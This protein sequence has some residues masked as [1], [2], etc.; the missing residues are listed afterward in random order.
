MSSATSA[1]QPIAYFHPTRWGDQFLE[2]TPLDKATQLEK[3]QE[4]EHLKEEVRKELLARVANV[5]KQLELLNFVDAIERLG[6]AYYLEKEIE[7]ALLQVYETYHDQCDK[8]DLYH[9]STRFRILRQHGYHVS[10][11]VFKK[12]KNDQGGLD[13]CILNDTRG[14]LSLYEASHVRIHGDDILDEAIAFTTTHLKLIVDKLSSP[15]AEQVVHALHQPLHLGFVRLESKHYIGFYEQ[16][17]SHNKTL[18]N[19]AKLDFNLLQLLHR[20]ELQDIDSWWKD[21]YSKAPFA[22]DRLVE[23]HFWILGC[24]YEP[25]YCRARQILIKLFMI[26]EVFDDIFDAYGSHEILKLFVEAVHRWDYSYVAQLP[27]Y[28]NSVYQV[29]LETLDGFEKELAEEGRSYGV[30]I[31]KEQFYRGCKAWL[32]EAGWLKKKY[33]PKYDEYLEASIVSIGQIQGIIGSY[34]GI[35]EPIA[36]KEDFEW[37]CQD[38]MPK[39][40]EASLMIIRLLN[41]IASTKI[42]QDSRDH[43]VS[44]VQC[45]MKETGITDEQHVY[46]VLEKKVEDAWKDLNQGML[47]PYSIP[48]PLLDRIIN[49]A[50]A[51]EIF[52]KGR[53]DGFTIVNQIIQD[54]IASLLFEPIPI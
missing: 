15:L 5:N 16:D 30:Q 32:R 9:V 6:L 18:L 44:S 29:L 10:C 48:K 52:Y 24:Y 40:V 42:E 8:D 19:L 39:V 1:S 47:R 11:D 4:V 26:V 25:K 45:Y 21:L 13:D 37:V 36:T 22:R 35:T 2:F 14:I 38:P 43:V 27:E 17:A 41:D 12:F 33:T 46:Q 51:P 3:V 54:K 20:K 7:E 50:R 23:A 34:L 28:F 49:L 53:T 31:Y